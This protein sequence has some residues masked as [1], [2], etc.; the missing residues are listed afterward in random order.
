MVVECIFGRNPPHFIRLCRQRLCELLG[1][2]TAYNAYEVWDSM[3]P[4]GRQIIGHLYSNNMC[5]PSLEYLK[6]F[7]S[8]NNDNETVISKFMKY[9][10]GSPALTEPFIHVEMAEGNL[11]MQVSTCTSTIIIP[12]YVESYEAFETN[13]MHNLESNTF[14]TE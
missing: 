4:T 7:L 14:T 3:R 6:K 5:H 1:T 13:L 11:G 9:V 12:A 2:L 10:T 8:D